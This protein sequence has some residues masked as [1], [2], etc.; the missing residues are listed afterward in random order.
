MSNTTIDMSRPNIL[1][2]TGLGIILATS[3][4]LTAVPGLAL[5][6]FIE[7]PHKR[8]ICIGL[9]GIGAS[10]GILAMFKHM[11]RTRMPWRTPQSL[12]AIPYLGFFFTTLAAVVLAR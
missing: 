2:A 4:L 10:L 8:E 12:V 3:F 7:V 1:Y 11:Q 9:F 6:N 5:S